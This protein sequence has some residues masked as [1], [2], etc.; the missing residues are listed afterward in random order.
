MPETA[1][2]VG[3]LAAQLIVVKYLIIWVFVT[4]RF[5]IKLSFRNL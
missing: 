3:L 5:A 4:K 1:L 2:I